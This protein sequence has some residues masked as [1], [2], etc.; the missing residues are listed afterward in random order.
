MPE[1][2]AFIAC[3]G[4]L[5]STFVFTDLVQYCRHGDPFV[6]PLVLGRTIYL[7]TP[8]VNLC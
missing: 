2:A 6:V 1:C 7:R 3:V 4:D 5:N 8:L